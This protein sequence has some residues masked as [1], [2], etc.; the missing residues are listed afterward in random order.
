MMKVRAAGGRVVYDGGA[1][2]WHREYGTQN[3][4]GREWKRH[5]RIRNRQRFVDR[6]GPQAFRTVL[7]D[8]VLGERRW[9][10]APLHVA[11]TLTKDDASAGWGDYYTAHEL[12]DALAGLGWQ[13]S[14]I[15][16]RGDKWYDL[17]PTI[18][19]VVAL[20][21]SFDVR[22]IPRGIVTIAWIRNWTDRWVEHPWFDEYDVI[23]ASSPA[24]QDI[25]ASSSEHQAALMPLATNPERFRPGEAAP[26][27]R[28]D[29]VFVGNRWG[30]T[31]QIEDILPKIAADHRVRV[32]GRGLGRVR[33]GAVRR[34]AAGLR[35]PRGCLQLG[36]PRRRRHGR[37]DAPVRVRELAGLRLARQRRPRRVGQRGRRPFAVRG[38]VP[39]RD[40]RGPASCRPRLD[41]ARARRGRRAPGVAPGA[42]AR[43]A[44]LS[45]P[46]RGS[47]RPP[48]AVGRGGP[49]CDP[50]GSTGLGARAVLGRLPLRPEPP[51]P[52]RGAGSSGTGPSA[53][54]L[55]SL[56]IGTGG[57]RDP[58][59]WAQR[60]PTATFAV[61]HP[62]GHQPP[63]PRDRRDV[64]PL[65]PRVR[66]LD[67]LRRTG[68][69]P[70]LTYR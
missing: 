49:L 23:L 45:P 26:E 70:R 8:R 58:P 43:A 44:H 21:D 4:Q 27:L 40:R 67:R 16:R 20:L 57:C 61:Q 53:R 12:G 1:V 59:A 46:Q 68:S 18:D 28:S 22:R 7:R 37:A 42:G 32:F 25:V 24:S 63:G 69:R 10:E 62:V 31:R 5:N 66:R 14:Y 3:A 9:S 54:R 36:D 65:R 39:G 13:V 19:V 11:V 15:E 34:R 64:R 30:V 60:S 48:P 33:I 2:L 38:A 52:V 17:D 50:R 35:P 56:D 41:R 29:V 55:G 6:W 47:P 51:A